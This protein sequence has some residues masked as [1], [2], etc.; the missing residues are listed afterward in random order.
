MG[1]NF[2]TEGEE[3][4]DG[5]V[6]SGYNSAKNINSIPWSRWADS[7]ITSEDKLNMLATEHPWAA[8]DKPFTLQFSTSSTYKY[9]KVLV[10]FSGVED[11]SAVELTIDG[12]ALTF[13]SRGT[14]DRQFYFWK[15]DNPLPNGQ[16]TL[17]VKQLKQPT[18]KDPR[19]GSL[20]GRMIC[21][22][23]IHEYQNNV[24]AQ[25]G[26]VGAFPTWDIRG[27]KSYRPTNDFCIMRNMT[28]PRFCP[29]C[30]EGMHLNFLQ[31][32]R[33]IDGVDIKCVGKFGLAS[34]KAIPY[35]Q[36]NK[37]RQRNSHY[38]IK[39]TVDGRE[40]VQFRDQIIATNLTSGSYEV[41]LELNTP[42]V[43]VD[44]KYLSDKNLFK[45]A[46]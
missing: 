31:K 40:L 37:T 30:V 43:R 33:L 41:A 35:G 2:A 1:H 5:Y 4:D 14:L 17:Q 44:T 21:S 39:W 27:S 22:L 13:D 23:D 12:K 26:K 9:W 28:S 3:Y 45:I 34:V 7:P 24:F 29:V 46:C 25:F 42:H 10:S 8:L 16:H 38:D 36:F 19:S 6:Y 15:F 32:I 18:L 11:A 20:M